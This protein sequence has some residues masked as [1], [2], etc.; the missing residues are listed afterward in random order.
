TAS[1]DEIRNFC[2]GQIA[3][4]KIPRYLKFVDDF[5]LTVTGKVQKFKMREIAAA[6]LGLSSG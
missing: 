5:P 3:H 4:F 1:E 2:Q 6:E